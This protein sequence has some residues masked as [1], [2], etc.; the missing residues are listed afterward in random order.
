MEGL[1]CSQSENIQNKD[2]EEKSDDYN[3]DFIGRN[4]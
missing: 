4:F 3:E 2:D 1:S